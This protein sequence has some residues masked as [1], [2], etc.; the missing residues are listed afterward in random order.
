[1]PSTGATLTEIKF[2]TGTQI[3]CL[4]AA[5]RALIGLGWLFRLVSRAAMAQVR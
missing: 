1:M 4:T 5:N 3:F 2:T